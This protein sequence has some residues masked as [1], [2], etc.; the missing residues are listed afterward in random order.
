MRSLRRRIY[1]W[2]DW[3]AP[4]KRAW[5]SRVKRARWQAAQN[6]KLDAWN[7]R[8]HHGRYAR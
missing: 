3:P 8:H 4:G 2:L 5:N 7:R 6:E 1:R